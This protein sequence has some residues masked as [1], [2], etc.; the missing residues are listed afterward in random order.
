LRHETKVGK[1]IKVE[2]YYIKNV[3]NVNSLVGNP[4]A[5]RAAINAD[6]PGIGVTAI[7]S[8]AYTFTYN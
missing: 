8:F 7:F 1:R 6:A 2:N 4:D 5:E 3:P